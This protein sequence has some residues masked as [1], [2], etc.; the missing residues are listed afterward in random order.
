MHAESSFQNKHKIARLELWVDGLPVS[1]A[2]PGEPLIW[3]TRTASDGY[4][5]LRLVAVDDDPIETRSYSRYNIHVSNK[6]IDFEIKVQNKEPVFHEPIVL[7]GKAANDTLIEIY[8]GSRV[9]GSTKVKNGNWKIMIPGEKLG[10]GTVS[11]SAI[12]TGE[13]GD[14]IYRIALLVEY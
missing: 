13:N 6:A 14:R 2:L 11:L 10:I 4:H 1:E 5:D 7:T 3:D 12:A 8:Q 9:L